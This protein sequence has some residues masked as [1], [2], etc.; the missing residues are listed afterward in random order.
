LA[1]YADGGDEPPEEPA[2]EPGNGD[3]GGPRIVSR[4]HE[5]PGLTRQA[6]RLA[7]EQQDAADRLGEQL[8]AGNLN[9]GI[10]AK[11]IFRGGLEARGRNGAGVYFRAVGDTIEILGKSTKGNQDQVIRL[12]QEIYDSE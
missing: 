4:I 1:S 5:S 10:G 11:S 9:P 8:A 2:E 12:L 6:S 7:G 3:E